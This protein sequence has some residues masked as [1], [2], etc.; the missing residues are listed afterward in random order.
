MGESNNTNRSVDS[1]NAALH[2]LYESRL[3]EFNEQIEQCIN[4]CGWE[5]VSKL[6]F[7]QVDEDYLNAPTKVLFVGR[8]TYGWGK[9]SEQDTV[10]NL[11]G[12]YKETSN[13]GNHHNSPF[14]WFRKEFSQA[15]GIGENFM[16]ATLWTNLSKIDVS[17][18]TPMGEKFGHLSQLFMSLLVA[19]INILKPDV[20]LIMTTNGHYNWHINNYRWIQNEPFK[21][22]KD[23][24]QLV[25]ESVLP[26][27]IDQLIATD[28]LPTHTYQLCHPNTLRWK[29][30]GYTAHADELIRTLVHRMNQ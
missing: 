16:K 20:V 26:G 6:F 17:R 1:I 12:C 21:D 2:S 15:I 30:G 7:M 8:E 11:M 18:K 25:R 10:E 23:D 3:P 14:W 5:E 24:S 27:K 13:N 19:E 22:F 4:E 28:R 9:Y 29:K